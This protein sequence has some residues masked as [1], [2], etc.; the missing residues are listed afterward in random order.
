MTVRVRNPLARRSAA[1]AGVALSLGLCAG[2]A[3]ASPALHTEGGRFVDDAGR[4]V[5]LRGINV[6]ADAKVPPFR[7]V[8]SPS[9]FDPIAGWGMNVV[10]LIFTW[11]A[12]EPTKGTYDA[13][14]LDAFASAVDGAASRRLFVVVDFHQDAYSRYAI[15]G[16]GDGFPA[17]AIPAWITHAT[18]D[19]GASCADWSTKMLL[20]TSMH[21]TWNAFHSNADGARASYLTMI[22]SVARRLVG[23]SAVVGYD[24]I[25]EP[26][27]DE[28]TEIHALYEDAAVAIRRADPTAILFVSP[29]A[30]TSSGTKSNLTKPSFGN[31][32]YAQHF[33]DPGVVVS[34]A[35]NGS[36]LDGPFANMR[37]VADAFGAPLFVGELGASPATTNHHAYVDA[38]FDELDVNLASGAQWSYTAVW[39]Q[40]AKD[41][42]NTEDFSVVDDTGATRTNFA[43]RPY[44]RR[45]AGVPTK[46][47]STGTTV[48]DRLVELTWE[49]APAAG[50]TE[51]YAPAQAFFGN[52]GLAATAIGAG[53]GCTSSGDIV[54]CASPSSGT[55][56]V[57]IRAASP[58]PPPTTPPPSTG[59]CT[60]ASGQAIALP[61][62]AF[63][64]V[65]RR[66][67]N[68]KGA[69]G[70]NDA[71]RSKGSH[72]NE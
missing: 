18:P 52:G 60:Q 46:F 39:S 58:P 69:K 48:N 27:G 59:G 54:R 36:S 24:M 14:Y 17:W 37:G 5:I 67:K 3:S 65:G 68:R 21:A 13:S 64:V 57:Q 7:P 15:S 25:N 6:A 22:E 29:H 4:T 51:I 50:E 45:T 34:H 20:D 49:N 10:R 11:E 62:I 16:C 41:G 32:A 30:L 31:F 47:A 35:W 19:N 23:R 72:D 56:R 40:A 12:Y 2:A 53:L 66:R 42:W 43:P 28:P 55:M 61:A 9:Y 38:L 8:T 1:A 70:A 26:W 33:Y 63:F 44:P 71:S